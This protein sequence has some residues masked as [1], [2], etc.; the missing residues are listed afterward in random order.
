MEVV[1]LGG[2]VLI[3][4]VWVGTDCWV[5]G[6]PLGVVGGGAVREVGGGGVCVEVLV[7]GGCAVVEGGAGVLDG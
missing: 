4:A 1:R 5:L 6:P 2:R 7:V 3:A